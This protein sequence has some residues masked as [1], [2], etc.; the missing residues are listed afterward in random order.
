VHSH[1]WQSG[2]AGIAL[3]RSLGVP[4]VHSQHTLGLVKNSVL[5]PGDAPEPN[6]RLEGE[7]RVIDDADVLIASTEEEAQ[8]L[9]SLYGASY[10]GIKTVHPGVD[11]DVFHPGDRRLARAELGIGADEAVLLYVGRIQ[12]LKGLELAV[13]AAHQVLPTL[14]RKLNFLVVGGAS[15]A[16]GRRELE[17]TMGLVESLDLQNHVRLVG[18]IPHR[19]LPTYYRAADVLTVGSFSE[20]FGLAA[21][22]ASA[23]GTPVVA[24][25]VGGLSYIVKEGRS[26]FLL[27]ER[28]PSAYASRLK[29]LLSDSNLWHEF[30]LEAI[31][32][33][34]SFGWDLTAFNLLEL[35]ECLAREVE[36]EACTC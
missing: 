35:Y 7:Q 31:R 28:D 26:G 3:A 36:P 32:A 34:S 18:S 13:R 1:Y 8:Q 6:G 22:E 33:A 25:A 19:R 27:G 12:P 4:L 11:H 2:I 9:V 29:T 21:L 30:S 5:A 16:S 24:T 14:H 20:S 15:G 10:D 17:R 23:C